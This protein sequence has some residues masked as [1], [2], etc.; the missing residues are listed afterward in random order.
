MLSV[1]HDMPSLP[2]LRHLAIDSNVG[3]PPVADDGIDRT[4]QIW[5][6]MLS[7]TKTWSCPLSSIILRLSD[8]ITIPSSLVKE[9]L[10]GHA[11]TLK[12]ISL[13]SCEFNM[14]SLRSIAQ[15]CTQL[16]KFA[17]TVPTRDIVSSIFRAQTV[18]SRLFFIGRL[19]GR[20]L[21]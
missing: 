18:S 5:R 12:S 20:T 14:L 1:P 8:K 15:R 2:H 16:E 9:L 19:L 3:S 21:V 4:P 7:K 10:D 13:I 17:V 6:F 11:S